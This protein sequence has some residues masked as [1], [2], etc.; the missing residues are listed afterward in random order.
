VFAQRQL[1][2]AL[3]RHDR[4]GAAELAGRRLPGVQRDIDAARAYWEQFEGRASR[5]ARRMNN[6]YLHSQRVPGGILSYQRSV[7]LLIAYAR[8]R[9]GW[10]V[11]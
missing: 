9:G 5:T 4:D 2:S 1:L 3:A 7:E 6:A 10:L 8:S 11:R